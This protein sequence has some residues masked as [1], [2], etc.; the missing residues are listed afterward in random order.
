MNRKSML[1]A[2]RAQGNAPWDIVVIGGGATGAGIAVDAAV[3]GYKTLLVE[4]EDFGKATSSRSTKL[5]HGGVRY[6]EQG[7]ISL[8][9]E[10]LKERGLLRQNAPHLVHDLPFVVPNYEWWEAPFYGIGMKV[11]DLLATKYSFGKSRILSREETLQRLP[12]IEQNGL[13][14]GVVYHDG[15]F[16]DTRLLTHLVMTAADHGATMLNYCAAVDLQRGEDGF[17]RGVV[18]ED[19]INKEHFD[20]QAKVVVNATGI[21]TDEV[22]HMAE[23]SAQ[24]MVAPSQG[25]HLV[26]EKSFLRGDTAI[27]VPRTSDGRVLFAIP[28]HDHTVVG[29]T[30]T[31]I[32]QPCYEPK[33]FAEEIEFVLET[34]AEYLSRKPTRDDILSIYVGIRPLVKASGGDGSKT[35]ALSRDHT[36][37]IDSSGLLTIVGGKWTTYRHMAEDTVNHAATLG[38]LPDVVCTTANMRVHGWSEAADLGHLQVY[39]SDAEK[40]RTLAEATPELAQP[41]HPALPYIA[42][43]V[44]WAVREEMACT[45]EDVLSRRTRA[46]LLNARAAIEMAPR[47]AELMARELGNDEA[48]QRSQVQAF[49]LLAQQ[50]LPPAV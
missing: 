7:N 16:D 43:E 45:V 39:G 31:S 27:M 50:Y 48:W 3:R 15:Q 26:F 34:A 49:E 10:A 37:H 5:V 2:V 13:R 46:L 4:R 14:G 20:V 8:V 11:Y 41:L 47:V 44:V 42:A 36:I 35:S 6:L 25:I 17:L 38:H 18:L 28:W 19:R 33:P 23:P 9:M 40:I 32:D 29:T 12:T 21:F 1:E 30:D 22:R 24:P